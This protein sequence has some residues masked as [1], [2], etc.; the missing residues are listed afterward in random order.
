MPPNDDDL[1]DR[2]RKA[3]ED[4]EIE[5]RTTPRR[6]SVDVDEA[7]AALFDRL[8]VFAGRVQA[9]EARRSEDALLLSSGGRGVRFRATDAGLVVTYEGWPVAE[10]HAA[11]P[12]PA[13]DGRWVLEFHR[14]G[15][16]EQLP[17]FDRGLEELLVHGLGLPRPA[18]SDRPIASR[19][20][21]ALSGRVPEARPIEAGPAAKSSDVTTTPEPPKR[22]KRDL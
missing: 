1:A 22:A 3:L 13:L 5:Q 16:V 20:A 9:I 15:R 2:F 11:W 12:E 19:T 7:R 18:A 10:T 17:M 14:L 6:P 8:A 4:Q 21:A